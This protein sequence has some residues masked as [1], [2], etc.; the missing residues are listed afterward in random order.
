MFLKKHL[1]LFQESF[2]CFW[3]TFQKIDSSAFQRNNFH[4]N[5]FRLSVPLTSG[6]CEA[7][8]EDLVDLSISYLRPYYNAAFPVCQY[9]FSSFLNFFVHILLEKCIYSKSQV[10][11]VYFPLEKNHRLTTTP[12]YGTMTVEKGAIANG[13]RI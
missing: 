13:S 1:I 4:S 10:F 2:S 7:A 8:F 9:I 3:K 12:I 5:C 6:L 11:L